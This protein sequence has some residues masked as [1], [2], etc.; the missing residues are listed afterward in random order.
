MTFDGAH[1]VTVIQIH[2]LIVFPLLIAL[3]YWA[4]NRSGLIDGPNQLDI[5]RRRKAA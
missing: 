5:E 1:H 2:A 3:S 4:G